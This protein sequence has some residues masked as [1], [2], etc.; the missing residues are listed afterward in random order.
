MNKF[1]TITFFFSSII[2][3]QDILGCMDEYAGNYN[4]DATVDDESCTD[5]PDNGD[6]SLSFDGIDD[7]GYLPWNDQLSSYTVSMWVRANDLNQI[8]YQAYFNN[9]STPNQGFQLDCNNNQEYRLL[10]SNGSIIL[11]SLD[12]EWTHV[13]VTSD[14]N[15]TSAYFNGALVETVN[16]TVTGWD[17][18]VLGRNRSTNEPG[19]YNI[20]EITIWNTE[21]TLEDIQALMNQGSEY[22]EE[23][24]LIQWKANMGTGD[25]L[26]D[27]SGNANHM[28][29][30]GASWID[31]NPGWPEIEIELDTITHLAYSGEISNELFTIYNNGDDDLEWIFSFNNEERNIHPFSLPEGC[32]LYTSPSPRD[33][34]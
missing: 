24:L 14:G 16:W 27:H 3:A 15:S 29:L 8:A 10:S 23:G 9:S 7:Y 32:L 13:A 4:R 11:A 21:K 6:F 30:Y 28:T 20:D 25:L 33:R 1:I 19:N 34:H 31:G 2:F 5:Y 17:Q 18:I 22:N 12:L 26:F